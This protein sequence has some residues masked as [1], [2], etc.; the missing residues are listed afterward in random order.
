[1]AVCKDPVGSYFLLVTNK[2][3]NSASMTYSLSS[4]QLVAM[5]LSVLFF[6]YPACLLDITEGLVFVSFLVADQIPFW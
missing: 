4:N 1:M 5:G 2:Y 6:I 3:N